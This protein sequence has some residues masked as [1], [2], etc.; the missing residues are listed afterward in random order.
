MKSA[1]WT[2]YASAAGAAAVCT[3]IGHAMVPRF[4]IVNVAMVYLL[5]VVLVALVFTRGAAIASAFL[6]VAAFDYSFVPP[7]GAFTVDDVQ[8]LLTFAIM[9]VVAVVITDLI[10]R[11]RA[12]S[13]A[14]A[15]LAIEAE[16]ERVRST[17]LASISHDL[18]TPL[19]VI[20]G[21][22]SS[23]AE[24]GERMSRQERAALAQGIFERSRD[25]TDLVAKVLQMTRLESGAIE[26]ERDRFR[27]ERPTTL[28]WGHDRCRFWMIRTQR[29]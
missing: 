14:Q 12:Q 29:D 21:A 13:V 5:A 7:Q 6:C 25:M 19:A 17:L 24:S 9:V 28:G 20:A 4:D 23:L 11:T 1:P 26:P 18:R 2:G 8:Y 27:M 22:A 3:L 10:E 15:S 16:T